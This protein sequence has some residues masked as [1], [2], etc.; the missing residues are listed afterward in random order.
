MQ[1]HEVDLLTRVDQEA[2]DLQAFEDGYWVAIERG[3]SARDQHNCIVSLL[4]TEAIRSASPVRA[5]SFAS[6]TDSELLTNARRAQFDDADALLVGLEAD[7]ELS[8]A[9]LLNA[10]AFVSA[11]RRDG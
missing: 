6:G 10:L 9:E 1:I 8:R 11:L 2:G 4:L 3:W 7:G 5:A